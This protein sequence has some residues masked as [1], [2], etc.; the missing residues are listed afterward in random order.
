MN[1]QASKAQKES[2]FRY[3][4]LV[5]VILNAVL[6]MLGMP[7]IPTDFGPIISAGLVAVVGLWVGFKNNYLTARGKAQAATLSKEGLLKK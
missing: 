1:Y 4:A 7:V 3:T 2:I 6:T 5:L